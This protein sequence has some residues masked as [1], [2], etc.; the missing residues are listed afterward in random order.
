MKKEKTTEKPPDYRE[1]IEA[2]NTNRYKDLWR[3]PGYLIRRL[4]QIH[5]GLF[6]EACGPENVTAVQFAILSVLQKNDCLDQLSLSKA[7][8]IDR[9]SGADVIKR[10]MRN[11]LVTREI[12]QSDG[13]AKVVRITQAGHLLVDEIQP[14]MESAQDK[15]MDP[16][17]AHE[18]VIF[19]SLLS[20]L[21][22]ANNESSRAPMT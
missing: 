7:V 19:M 16:L 2:K 9:T 3:R 21:I 13:R 20:R 6:A 11:G 14:A 22:E 8:G 10:L 1:N 12:S 4:H 17:T 15:L 5:V 18:Q